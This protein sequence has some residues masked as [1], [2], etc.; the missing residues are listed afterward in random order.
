MMMLRKSR[1]LHRK[2]RQERGQRKNRQSGL[3]A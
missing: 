2:Q 1:C 3:P